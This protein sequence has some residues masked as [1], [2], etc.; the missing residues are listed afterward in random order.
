MLINLFTHYPTVIF[1][2]E[3]IN[4]S[5][6]EANSNPQA[7]FQ[8]LNF[9]FAKRFVRFYIGKKLALSDYANS[10]KKTHEKR[11]YGN[12]NGVTN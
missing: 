3:G 11:I 2:V 12:D 4:L 6:F 5:P 8:Y 9:I 10:A 1:S 7:L